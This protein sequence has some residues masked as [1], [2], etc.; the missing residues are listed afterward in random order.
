[1]FS[2]FLMLVM[3]LSNL[4][5]RQWRVRED[6]TRDLIYLNNTYDFRK[7][8]SNV[9]MKVCVSREAQRRVEHIQ[10]SY[11]QVFTEVNNIPMLQ[12]YNGVKLSEWRD[13]FYELH[14]V[15][16]YYG[17][18]NYDV[19]HT[20]QRY[21]LTGNEAEDWQDLSRQQTVRYVN[22]LFNQGVNRKD[23]V[24]ILNNMRRNE[25]KGIFFQPEIPAELRIHPDC[26]IADP[27]LMP[28]NA[29][30]QLRQFR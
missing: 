24:N 17:K 10:D 1:L 28:Q 25:L 30:Q 12:S 16:S 21:N 8:I 27:G 23:I 26:A 22:F 29:L 6:S 2:L 7:I 9:G 20:W 3:L 13:L 14:M 18:N 19:K 11:Y 15:Y 4:D 5:S